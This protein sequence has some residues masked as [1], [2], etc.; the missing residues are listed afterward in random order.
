MESSDAAPLPPSDRSVRARSRQRHAGSP[1][2]VGPRA[3]LAHAI[4]LGG[5]TAAVFMAG[6]T[7]Q[8]T[9]GVFLLCAGVAMVACPPRVKVEWRLW[10]AAAAVLGCASLALLPEHTLP[11]P[12]WRQT[13]DATPPIVMPGTISL[14]PALTTY[15][16]ELLAITLLVG[17]FGLAHP[18][19][20]RWLLGYAMV[21]VLTTGV[22]GAL[23]IYARVTGW[24]YPFTAGATFGFFP[25]RNHTATLLFVGSVAAVGVLSVVLREGR[26]FAGLLVAASLAVC[27]AGLGF[28]S[29]SRGGIVF[30][31]LG[32]LVWIAGLGRRHRD[33]QLVVSFFVLLLA[34]GILVLLSG[35]EVRTRL[36]SQTPGNAANLTADFRL[37]LYRDVCGAIRDFPLTGSGLGSFP[38]VFPQYQHASLTEYVV[39]HP[40]SDW[41]LLTVET[42][43]PTVLCLLT[44]GALAAG[45]LKAERDHPYWPLRWGLAAAVGAAILHGLVDIPLHVPALGW[46]LVVVSGLALQSVRTGAGGG[47]RVQQALFVAG[48]MGALVLGGEFVRAQWFG[49]P[50]TTPF[51]YDAEVARFYRLVRTDPNQALALAQQMVREHPMEEFAYRLLGE[52]LC[53]FDNTETRVDAAFRA[54]R[55]LEPVLTVTPLTQGDDWFD[56][57]PA[58]AATFWLDALARHIR[59]YRSVGAGQRGTPARFFADLIQRAAK[60]PAAQNV[61]WSAVGQDPAFA[62]GWVENATPPLP[63]EGIVRLAANTN[64]LRGLDAAGQR[65]FLRDWYNR[66]DRD[67]L[68]AFLDGRADWQ[69][70]AW[71]V[72]LTRLADAGR[73]EQAVRDGAAHYG[74]SLD[75][76]EPGSEIAPPPTAEQEASDPAA[77]FMDYWKTGNVRSAQRVLNEA[78]DP[79]EAA[80]L[81][82]LWRLRT[83][84]AAHDAD[85]PTAWR[86]LQREIT[87]THPDDAF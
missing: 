34:G 63:R 14:T 8:G 57:D 6:R 39:L 23:A 71:P 33:R 44:L 17:L 47:S 64:F 35:G 77:A 1:V 38:A 3:L 69:A 18:I 54:E 16:L 46:W 58:H 51:V 78:P 2:P 36:L 45:R 5:A 62:F 56:I 24:H 83:A 27:V 67:A 12:A 30:L 19:R 42:G 75:L 22:Y 52:E 68:A 9:P 79:A 11:I 66:G 73:Y 29:G 4:L 65:R 87:T 74:V 85:W 26:W 40:D 21:I 37:K 61:L 20:S 13:F 50:P 41:L 10:L 32:I 49:G 15:W 76:P 81:V 72:R 7:P 59:N 60:Q 25:N 80:S 48:G 70:A 86:D 55:L 43:I 28:F 82:E 31:L 53:L 84:L